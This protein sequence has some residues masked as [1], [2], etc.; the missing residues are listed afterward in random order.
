MDERE[1]TDVY[2]PVLFSD[3]AVD[4]LTAGEAR[5]MAADAELKAVI[6]GAVAARRILRSDP[7]A[8]LR[9]RALN[10]PDPD[11]FVLED[12]DGR[13][14]A[15]MEQMDDDHW[16]A[17][18]YVLTATEPPNFTGDGAYARARE[19]CEGMAA[20]YLSIRRLSKL[21]VHDPGGYEMNRP[22]RPFRKEQ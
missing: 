13:V 9:W 1:M 16:W 14:Y 19:Y 15:H 6:E 12:Q 18:A 5:R 11:D 8:R 3:R 10:P 21:P 7:K 22:S 2:A 17:E 20:A 4:D